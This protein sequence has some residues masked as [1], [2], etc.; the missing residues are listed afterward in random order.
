MQCNVHLYFPA[1]RQLVYLPFVTVGTE[2]LPPGTC[3]KD[4]E[5]GLSSIITGEDGATIRN[6]R[7]GMNFM[8]APESTFE[9]AVQDAKFSQLYIKPYSKAVMRSDFLHAGDEYTM[10]MLRLSIEGDEWA[11]GVINLISKL[12]S[13]KFGCKDGVIATSC[14]CDWTCAP[15]AH[16][17]VKQKDLTRGH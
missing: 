15:L 16:V 5:I 2:M 12:M 9:S 1:Q 13:N 11:A 3:A 14:E 17:V 6:I 4:S 7:G 10:S 8:N